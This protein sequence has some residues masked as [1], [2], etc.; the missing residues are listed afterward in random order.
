[1]GTDIDLVSYVRER[2]PAEYMDAV[3]AARPFS[4]SAFRPTHREAWEICRDI[5]A[6]HE[7]EEQREMDL[8][9]ALRRM[10]VWSDEHP[11]VDTQGLR[12]CDWEAL[13][14]LA[15]GLRLN[16]SDHV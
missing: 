7:Y 12:D 14:R 4:V 1:M 13:A 16:A 6:H 9:D 10:Q 3:K 15:L 11:E 5:V 8:A 2:W